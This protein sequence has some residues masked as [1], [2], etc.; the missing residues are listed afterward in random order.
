[1]RIGF[2]LPKPGTVTVSIVDGGGN[3]IRRLADDRHMERGRQRFHWSGHDGSGS[4]P[5]DG[6]YY[7]RVALRDEGRA[8]TAPRGVILLTKPPRPKL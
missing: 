6:T 7:L 5:P 2:F 4:V 1:I 8:A 3:E